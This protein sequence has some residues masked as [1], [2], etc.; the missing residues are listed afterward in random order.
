MSGRGEAH[1]PGA[2]LSKHSADYVGA[3]TLASPAAC[4][5]LVTIIP[6]YIS[7]TFVFPALP[8]SATDYCTLYLTLEDKMQ[9]SDQLSKAGR[10]GTQGSD[11]A[12]GAFSPHKGVLF[13]KGHI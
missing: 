10:A 12:S 11:S 13:E 2:A 1:R 6:P 4:L 9:G 3:G 8:T 7:T 5:L